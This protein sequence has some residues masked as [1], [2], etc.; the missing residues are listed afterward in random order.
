MKDGLWAFVDLENVCDTIWYVTMLRVHG[1]G[2]KLLKA[3][4][5]FYLESRECVGQEWM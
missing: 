4:N 3:V 1:A 5:G 2:G